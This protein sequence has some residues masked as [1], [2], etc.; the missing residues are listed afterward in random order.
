MAVGDS[1]IAVVIG[2]EMAARRRRRR[3][4]FG[5]NAISGGLDLQEIYM[6]VCKY[7]CVY[8]E[9]VKVLAVIS[10]RRL[11]GLIGGN[12]CSVIF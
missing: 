9:D 1:G 8:V 5:G 2:I 3:R 6:Y 11:N 12:V 10:G 7:M 4:R